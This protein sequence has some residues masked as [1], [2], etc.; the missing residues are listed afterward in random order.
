METI[1]NP[2]AYLFTVRIKSNL[3]RMM[4][5]RRYRRSYNKPR[6]SFV[7]KEYHTDANKLCWKKYESDEAM[8]KDPIRSC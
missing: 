2:L 5:S 8:S 6:V 3:R 7:F 1:A 4:K